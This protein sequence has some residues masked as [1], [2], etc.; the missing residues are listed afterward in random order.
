MEITA[1]LRRNIRVVPILLNNTPM[2]EIGELPDDL[3]PLARRQALELRHSRFDDDA[4]YIVKRCKTMIVGNNQGDPSSV[5][6]R[7]STVFSL[8]LIIM[9]IASIL[10]GILLL[11]LKR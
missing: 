5:Q 4:E 3:K 7:A 6:V 8:T 10:G 2:P 1:A 11:V 9:L